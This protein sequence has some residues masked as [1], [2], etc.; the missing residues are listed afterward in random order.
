MPLYSY[1]A[2]NEKG[3]TVRGKMTAVNELELE[4]RL[5]GLKLDLVKSKTEKKAKASFLSSVTIKDLIIVC[6]HL[7]Q[8][9]RAG[10]PLLDSLSD[11]RDTADSPALRDLMAEIYENVK[12][13]TMLSDAMKKHPKVFGDVFVGLIKVGEETG[14]LS[15]SFKHLGEHLKWNEA[16]RAKVKKAIKY[17]IFLLILL[18]GVIALMMTFVVPQLSEF[19]SSQGFDLPIHTRALIATSEAFVNYWYLILGTPVL[20]VT[21]IIVFY[22]TSYK[23]AH[24]VDRILL[25]LPFIGP[26]VLKSNLSRFC[27]F[28]SVTF[29]SG[30]DILDSLDTAQNV[31]ENRII[32]DAIQLVRQSVSQGNSL[33]VS[34]TNTERF[35]NLV[36]RMFKVGE[37]SGNMEQ[38]LHNINFFYDREVN[39]SV[40]NIVGVI[41]P[42]LTIIMGLIL[43]WITAAVFGPLYDSFS[44]MEF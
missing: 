6:V 41:Q 7:E 34:L 19:L 8:L 11:L 20:I 35:P 24:F 43:F 25:H 42:A 1:S 37:D 10:V 22:K 36:L 4:E 15:E 5:K 21:L 18:S 44:K 31:V 28:F 29:V 3:Q 27:H 17:P 2:I 9:D 32:K 30:I 23:F 38:A 39:D 33:T 13:G 26:V 12:S 40:D 14:Q 16:L